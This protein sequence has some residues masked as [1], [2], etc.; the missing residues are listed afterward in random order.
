MTYVVDT[1]VATLRSATARITPATF[2]SR[3]AV[4]PHAQH[5]RCTLAPR[6]LQEGSPTRTFVSGCVPC[7]RRGSREPVKRTRHHPRYLRGTHARRF[8]SGRNGYS[9]SMTSHIRTCDVHS[10]PLPR[11]RGPISG[12]VIS[13]LRSPADI[14]PWPIHVTAGE[15]YGEDVQL[16][17]AVLYE[18]HYRGFDAST[19]NGNGCPVHS[20]CAH[21]WNS[22]SC[23][24][25]VTMSRNVTTRMRS[26]TL[27]ATSLTTHGVSRTSWLPT[28]RGSRS[29]SSS[30][31]V[32]STTSRKP[33]RT[34]GQFH[35]SQDVRKPHSSRSS[36]TSTAAGVPNE[37]TL[38][39][40]RT[41]WLRP[42]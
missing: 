7:G 41:C 9:R 27:C 8:D 38:G 18:M 3:R 26:S 6:V 17:L 5:R 34:R 36:S 30:C 24:R 20:A 13:R 35:D 15:P 10:A 23:T 21:N 37:Y 1:G 4:C 25:C 29:A 31:T 11:P 16:A 12:E 40:S 32:P 39:C 42:D 2:R 28:E 33:I 14:G 22:S 19:P